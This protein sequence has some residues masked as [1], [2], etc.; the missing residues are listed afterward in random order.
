MKINCKITLLMIS[1]VTLCAGYKQAVQVNS[2][3]GVRYVNRA[4]EAEISRSSFWSIEDGEPPI[5]VIQAATLATKALRQEHPELAM[6]HQLRSIWL[7]IGK[8]T[9]SWS[10]YT[11]TYVED[12]PGTSSML[13]VWVL[14]DGTV[15]VPQIEQE[16][17]DVEH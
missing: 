12:R 2:I 15:M 5:S 17:L 7:S 11:V 3:D 14:L 13:N 8:D 4:G 10:K 1:I 6:S 9:N 16:D